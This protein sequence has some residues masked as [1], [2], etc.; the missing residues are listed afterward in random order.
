[1]FGRQFLAAYMIVYFPAHVFDK[2]ENLEQALIV[3]ANHFIRSFDNIV[4][5]MS[6][7]DMSPLSVPADSAHLFLVLTHRYFNAFHAWKTPDCAALIGRIERSILMLIQAR[8]RINTFGPG[9]NLVAPGLNPVAPGPGD[10]AAMAELTAQIERMEIKLVQLAGAQA[11]AQFKATHYP[12]APAAALPD[13]VDG[14]AEM[15]VD[16][17]PGAA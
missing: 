7:G 15:A 3:A 16:P 9:L 8:D 14:D 10:L 12:V 17:D 6:S 13:S 4:A 1:M 2:I 5:D 11:A